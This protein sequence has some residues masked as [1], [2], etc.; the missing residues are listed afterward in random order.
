MKNNYK[1]YVEP[2]LQNLSPDAVA[3]LAYD[4]IFREYMKKMSNPLFWAFRRRNPD[5][6]I[7]YM[8]WEILGLYA[9]TGLINPGRYDD[10]HNFKAIVTPGQK[11]AVRTAYAGATE[12]PFYL[13]TTRFKNMQFLVTNARL[14]KFG[15]RNSHK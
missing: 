10:M 2:I 3:E 14:E 12:M 9:R 4:E 6:M 8:Y 5:V 11:T 13:T 1:N 15:L 7:N